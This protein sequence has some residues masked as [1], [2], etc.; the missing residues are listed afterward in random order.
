[1]YTFPFDTCEIPNKTGIA[2]PYSVLFNVL[3]C[4]IIIYFIFKTKNRYSFFLLFSILLFELFH[5]CSHSIHLKSGIQIVVTHLLAYL[6]NFAYFISLYNY[7]NIFP[8]IWFIL[9]I[10]CVIA[11][12]IYAFINLSFMYYITSQF[13]IFFSLFSYYYKYFGEKMKRKIPFIF[14]LV[15]LVLLLFLNE[16][17]NCKKMLSV[18]PNFPFHILIEIVA[19]VIVYNIC[20]IFYKL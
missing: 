7:S 4:F 18:F 10:C 9:Y 15:L 13:L 1:M 12:D 3:S 8:S 6:V 17:I 2:Q 20:K 19:S 16:S 14:G 11:F 5:T